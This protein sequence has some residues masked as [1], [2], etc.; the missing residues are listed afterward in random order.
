[1]KININYSTEEKH[2]KNSNA[3]Q[4]VGKEAELEPVRIIRYPCGRG[5][6]ASRYYYTA[7]FASPDDARFVY[8]GELREN[9]NRKKNPK[10]NPKNYVFINNVAKLN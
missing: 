2:Y 8:N 7:V 1:V 10:F 6:A 9:I 4:Y 3:F 5:A